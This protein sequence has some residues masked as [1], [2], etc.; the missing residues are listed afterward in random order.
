[1]AVQAAADCDGAASPENFWQDG[2]RPRTRETERAWTRVLKAQQTANERVR[3][4]LEAIPTAQ[5][6]AAIQ[7]GDR[8]YI[9][10]RGLLTDEQLNALETPDPA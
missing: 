5:R 6:L 1:M 10:L 4:T 7:A 9:G 2:E 3:T 8:L